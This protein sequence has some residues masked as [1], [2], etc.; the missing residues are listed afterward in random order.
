MKPRHRT[1]GADGGDVDT[2]LSQPFSCHRAAGSICVAP[3]ATCWRRTGGRGGLTST[4][5]RT[6]LTVQ[7]VLAL[8]RLMGIEWVGSEGGLGCCIHTRSSVLAAGPQWVQWHQGHHLCQGHP[9]A[10]HVLTW[11]GTWPAG[12]GAGSSALGLCQ[13]HV[14]SCAQGVT[15][16]ADKPM[17]HLQQVLTWALI[18]EI[19]ADLFE[20][21]S[22]TGQSVGE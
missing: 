4:M 17:E 19:K 12:Q 20:T 9:W 21:S 6:M 14:S 5:C 2:A 18:S 1:R 22:K 10:Q 8:S 16:G 13:P 3:R 11:A 15:L 7:L